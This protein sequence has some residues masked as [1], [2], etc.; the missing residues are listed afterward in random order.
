MNR[1]FVYSLF[2][3]LLV[4]G[5]RADLFMDPNGIDALL[6]QLTE[7]PRRQWLPQGMIQARHL[8]YHGFENKVKESTETVYYDG[9]KT[10]LDIMLEDSQS[11][12][13]TFT[14]SSRRQADQDFKLNQNRTFLWNGQQAV[15]YYKSADY[16]IVTTGADAAVEAPCGP[17]TAGIIP[18]GHGDFTFLVLKSQSPKVYQQYSDNQL[19]YI[20]KYTNPTTSPD[21]NIT[22]VLDPSKANAVLSYT[23]ENEM[24]CLRQTYQDYLQVDGQWIPAKVLIERFDKRS[25]SARLLSYE[26]WQF[27][28]IDASSPAEDIFA[29]EY[30]NGTTVEL[31]PGGDIETFLYDASDRVDIAAILAD[32]IN[33]LSTDQNTV[34]CA[35]AAIDHIAKRFSKQ[36]QKETL[37]GVITEDTRKTTL[38]DMKRTFEEAGLNCM[39][40]TTDLE[41]LD[42][43]DNCATILHLALTNHYVILDHVEPD[44]AWIIDLTNRQFFI[45]RNIDDLLTEWHSGTALLISDEPI[46][47]PLDVT[48]DYLNTDDMTEILGGSFGTYSCTNLIQ[49]RLRV[50]CDDAIGGF[51]CIGAYYVFEARKGCAEDPDGGICAG[52]KM[53]SYR[54]SQC[55]NDPET[56]G[57]CK[58]TGTWTNRY[59]RA[60]E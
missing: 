9:L 32:K 19:R 20:L 2:A 26:D 10:R 48:F 31:H 51:L 57:A 44:G 8:E 49:E 40:I 54:Y 33:L 46:T 14:G 58:I 4:T 30:Q 45:K 18:W 28:V 25:G 56:Q 38:Y 11:T 12:E 59:I 3:V 55:L 5:A 15:Q 52:R 36:L 21:I 29:I 41:T 39:A 50:P 6:R 53:P 16:A 13:T 34:N 24:A 42:K 37:A 23:I 47:P 22:F 17:M 27:D 35:T 1:W 43:I 7:T 60:C